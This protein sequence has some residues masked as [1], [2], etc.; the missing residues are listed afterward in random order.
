MVN[1]DDVEIYITNIKNTG[2]RTR[3][4]SG[5][6]MFEEQKF[7]FKFILFLD[8]FTKTPNINVQLT[9]M[10]EKKLINEFKLDDVSI[11]QLIVNMQ[12]KILEGNRMIKG[13]ALKQHGNIGH[14]HE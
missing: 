10:T 4:S 11:E 9:K 1:L 5:Y 7:N 3:F 2:D 8:A 6:F 14:E 13:E 12:R